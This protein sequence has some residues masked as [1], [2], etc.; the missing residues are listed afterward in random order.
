MTDMDIIALRYPIGRFATPKEYS[1]QLYSECIDTIKN[2]P[3]IIKD[4][5][6]GA[7][8]ESYDTQYRPNGWNMAQVINHLADSHMN[9]LIRFKLGLTEDCPAIKPYEEGDWA[10]LAD[11]GRSTVD[12]SLLIL[13]GVHERWG[14]LLESMSEEDFEKKL[15]HPEQKTE[16]TLGFFL[17]LYSWHCNH[18]IGHIKLCI[19]AQGSHNFV[20]ILS[21]I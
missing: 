5:L 10:N 13:E 21:E 11:G 12:A 15:F 20:A 8:E 19:N 17:A 18:H 7:S 16:R 3:Q 14:V 4:L 2:T 9:S 1:I 6:K